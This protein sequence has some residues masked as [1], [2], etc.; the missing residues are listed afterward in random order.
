MSEESDFERVA[1]GLL[2]R[3][4]E[5]IEEAEADAVSVDT[6]P[7]MVTVE[8]ERAGTWVISKHAPTRQIWLS[9]PLSGASHYAPKGARWV[10]TRGDG[11]DLAARLAAELKQAAGLDLTLD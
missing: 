1:A 6:A 4:A 9:S 5:A 2:S 11:A 8:I 10:S 7:G 3:W